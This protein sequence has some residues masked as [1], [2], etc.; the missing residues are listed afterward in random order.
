MFSLED[1]ERKLAAWKNS[2]PAILT[3]TGNQSMDTDWSDPKLQV[4][5]LHH[6]S[7]IFKVGIVQTGLSK[8]IITKT[9]RK[10]ELPALLLITFIQHLG[11]R[12]NETLNKQTLIVGSQH[13]LDC[14]AVSNQKA[15]VYHGLPQ[16]RLRQ[17]KCFICSNMSIHVKVWWNRKTVPYLQVQRLQ[18]LA[19][20]FLKVSAA[21][22]MKQYK[23]DIPRCHQ[24]SGCK[25][26]QETTRLSS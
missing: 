4:Y 20:A 26:K 10:T 1:K 3:R 15:Q 16:W 9:Q 11:G 24:L 13:L 12:T 17:K 5:L 2:Q 23:L 25:Y 21:V 6:G 19:L 18:T 14:L 22:Q 7:Y 8:C